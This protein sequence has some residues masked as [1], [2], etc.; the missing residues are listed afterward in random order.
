MKKT[1]RTILTAVLITAS[2]TVFADKL[3]KKEYVNVPAGRSITMQPSINHLGHARGTVTIDFVVNKKGNVLAARAD[4]K[5]TTV[6][7]K[8]FVRKVEEAVMAMEFNKDRH[9]P[10]EQ[11]GSLAYSFR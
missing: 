2:V 4:R 8:A 10:D 6:R 1:I 5:H 9:A 7:D 3:P 11:R